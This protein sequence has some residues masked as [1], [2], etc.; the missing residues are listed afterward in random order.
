M[1][2]HVKGWNKTQ[3]NDAHGHKIDLNNKIIERHCSLHIILA[4]VRHN[5][6]VQF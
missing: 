5:L 4:Y 3:C 1:W 2:N 6:E